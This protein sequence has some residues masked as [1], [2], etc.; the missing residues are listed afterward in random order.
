MAFSWNR[1]SRQTVSGCCRKKSLVIPIGEVHVGLARHRALLFKSL[2]DAC[3]LPCKV[4][5]GERLGEFAPKNLP[6]SCQ[7]NNCCLEA[8]LWVK[9]FA[10]NPPNQ[11]LK[12]E[13]TVLDMFP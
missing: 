5:R 1:L 11:R 2:A 4:V 13:E 8:K 10:V 7:A 9:F 6:R 3:R 12:S